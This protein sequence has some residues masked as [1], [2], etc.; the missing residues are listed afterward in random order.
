MRDDE[1]SRIAKSEP[2]AHTEAFF[3][4]Q[5]FAPNP[6]ARPKGSNPMI[7]LI[8]IAAIGVPAMAG[9]HAP[10]LNGMIGAA[11]GKQ[12]LFRCLQSAMFGVSK[13]ESL[14]FASYA[15]GN[16]S[17]GLGATNPPVYDNSPGI[18]RLR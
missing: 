5:F 4:N 9:R 12:R 10:M 11:F 6:G 14:A 3:L 2:F 18:A 13:P 17:T 16:G 8:H 15:V 7:N 1:V